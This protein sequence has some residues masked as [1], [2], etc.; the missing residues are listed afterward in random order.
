MRM[1]KL[2]L[3]S[4]GF[5]LERKIKYALRMIY[6]M[7]CLLIC[8]KAPKFDFCVDTRFI[9]L[10]QDVDRNFPLAI[11]SCICFRR[12]KMPPPINSTIKFNIIQYVQLMTNKCEEKKE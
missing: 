3:I 2:I 12:T 7:E 5:V 1:I 8:L 9:S 11:D 6:T 4:V 10:Y